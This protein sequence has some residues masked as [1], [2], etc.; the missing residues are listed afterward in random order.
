MNVVTGGLSSSSSLIHQ[1]HNTNNNNISNSHR[2]EKQRRRLV[3][4][5]GPPKTASTSLQLFLSKY[6]SRESKSWNSVFDNWNY[7]RFLNHHN[8]LRVF[9]GGQLTKSNIAKIQT[10]FEQQ[11]STINLVIGSENL[12]GYN[13]MRVQ[14]TGEKVIDA[15]RNWSNMDDDITPEIVIQSR[16]PRISHLISVWKQS[17]RRTPTNNNKK[18]RFSGWSFQRYLCSEQSAPELKR[19]LRHVVNPIGVANLAVFDDKLPTTLMD[20]QGMAAQNIDVCHAFAC[21]VMN[22]EC[23]TTTTTDPKKNNQTTTWVKGMEGIVIRANSISR[24]P[25]LTSEQKLQ[26]EEVFRQ[27]DCN[28]GYDLYNHSLFRLF[29]GQ[30]NTWPFNCDYHE[31]NDDPK[32]YYYPDDPLVILNELRRI[33]QCPITSAFQN[34][35]GDGGGTPRKIELTGTI[36]SGNEKLSTTATPLQLL[37]LLLVG[38]LAFFR[39]FISTAI[40]SRRRR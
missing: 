40:R 34:G 16:G 17:T 13:S 8:G 29:Y 30:N 22:V 23:I 4:C 27:R 36:T 6:A 38:V 32:T 19:K 20:M 11:P 5:I 12:S 33:I 1:Q 18:R 26:M 3:I 15:L 39:F 25:H 7:P 14:I 9:Q 24:N 37:A 28:Y 10:K 2:N 21:S 31:N 35:T